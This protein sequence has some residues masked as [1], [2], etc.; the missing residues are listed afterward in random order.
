MP[1]QIAVGRREG[2]L[3]ATEVHNL[4]IVLPL[5]AGEYPKDG[6]TAASLDYCHDF[7]IILL[8]FEVD[9]NRIVSSLEEQIYRHLST[10]EFPNGQLRNALRKKR[11]VKNNSSAIGLNR[12]SEAAFQD[13]KGS[14]GGPGLGRASDR[15][16]S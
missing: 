14:G 6:R 15:I 1:H 10:A 7:D 4:K 13:Q 3:H 16:K 12:D 2:P 5:T 8:V 9:Q 11:P